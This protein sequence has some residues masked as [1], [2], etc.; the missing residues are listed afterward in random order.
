[1]KIIQELEAK[2]SESEANIMKLREE[3]VT[4]KTE[5]SNA[6]QEILSLKM[7]NDQLSQIK[8]LMQSRKSLISKKPLFEMNPSFSPEKIQELQNE[9]EK[10]D[11]MITQLKESYLETFLEKEKIIFELQTKLQD[12][13]HQELKK[14]IESLERK[15]E[16]IEEEL[17]KT[18]TALNLE[19]E[20]NEGEISAKLNHNIEIIMAGK[21]RETETLLEKMREQDEKES[22]LSKKINELES[23]N[24]KQQNELKLLTAKLEILKN[25]KAGFSKQF[26]DLQTNILLKEKEISSIKTSLG[27]KTADFELESSQLFEREVKLN[28]TIARLKNENKKQVQQ[29]NELKSNNIVLKEKNSEMKEILESSQQKYDKEVKE[30]KEKCDENLQGLPNKTTISHNPSLR[31]PSGLSPH[32][33]T[34][35]QEL[36]GVT[37]DHI[38]SFMENPV[39]KSP[40]IETRIR[41]STDLNDDETFLSSIKNQRKSILT[42]SPLALVPPIITLNELTKTGKE[43]HLSTVEDHQSE[44]MNESPLKDIDSLNSVVDIEDLRFEIDELEKENAILRRENEKIKVELK[45]FN[46]K[47]T[48]QLEVSHKR[49]SQIMNDL[50][51]Q[52]K[53]SIL[54]LQA[55]NKDSTIKFLQS[56]IT[57]LEAL[58]KVNENQYQEEKK[59][60]I[61]ELKEVEKKA[62]EAKMKYAQIMTER[63]M[64]ELKYKQL[65]R[66]GTIL[67]QKIPKKKNFFDLLLCND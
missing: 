62:I 9:L 61:M 46:E 30:L 16:I 67:P 63:D 40:N 35:S 48:K 49:E 21:A 3:E 55:N 13:D 6:K 1:M 22:E 53:E 66:E 15:V 20:K 39:E 33:R 59:F 43:E 29:I 65:S 12:S 17:E 23:I 34:L 56:E 42:S 37:C 36:G 41:F 57:R 7:E 19:H 11:K 45:E 18:Q 54:S 58:M 27:T 64:F 51:K 38:F 31:I 5:F 50:Q 28:E 10:R 14:I 52:R 47:F 26:C 4:M 25:E 2:L 24:R 32:K 60:W 44:N 8:L